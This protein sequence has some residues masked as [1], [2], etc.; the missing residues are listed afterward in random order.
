MTRFDADVVI[1]GGGVAG[2]VL[3]LALGRRGRRVIVL[4]RAA[5][6][7]LNGADVL[8]PAGIAVLRGL[9]LL[10]SIMERGG[11][12]RC[13]VQIFHDAT[14]VAE[15]DY[16]R[17]T[18][19]GS[20]FI[21]APYA[22]VLSSVLD[23][24]KAMPNVTYA[25]SQEVS[26][27]QRD[28]S[29]TMGMQA[30]GLG[31][32]RARY[33][34]GADGAMSWVRKQ[35]G[36]EVDRQ[37]YAQKLYFARFPAVPSVEELN[38]LYVDS[39]GALAYFYPVGFDGF[40]AV[41]GFQEAEGDSL[42]NASAAV[43]QARVRAFAPQSQDAISVLGT[44]DTFARIPVARMHA[45]EYGRGNVALLGDAIHNVHPITGQGMN[46]SIEDAGELASALDEEL[47]LGSSGGSRW[48]ERYRANRWAINEAVVEYGHGLCSALKDRE[49][50]VAS[51]DRQMQASRRGGLIPQAR[52]PQ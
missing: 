29:W 17:D 45:A 18:D 40:R 32:L 19:E 48:L 43:L 11:R 42:T 14:K 52:H 33:Y 47:G 38:R 37:T 8:K 41:L 5:T 26:H 35:I 4:E 30:S 44:L 6:P 10:E 16:R 31:L 23:A 46:L 39:T 27:V 25:T 20:Y 28:G 12:R 50:F 3:A 36:I 9:G 49:R 1:V 24:L 22:L 15:L 13:S 21:L 51:F 34:V 7:A 2:A